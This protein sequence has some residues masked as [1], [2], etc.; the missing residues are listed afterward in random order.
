[1][2]MTLQQS[3]RPYGI[4]ASLGVQERSPSGAAGPGP[5]SWTSKSWSS[6]TRTRT[7]PRRSRSGCHPATQPKQPPPTSTLLHGTH[8]PFLTPALLHEPHS[9]FWTHLAKRPTPSATSTAATTSVTDLLWCGVEVLQAVVHDLE[10]LALRR[11]DPDHVFQHLPACP[12]PFRRPW[13]R[14]LG[15]K[16]GAL[17]SIPGSDSP[18]RPFL[19]RSVP[20]TLPET[21]LS[22]SRLSPVSCAGSTSEAARKTQTTPNRL[23]KTLTPRPE[24]P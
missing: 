16:N 15:S 18:L 8:S 10:P 12:T 13:S 11:V 1:M 23:S 17:A 22:L 9:S 6:P 3:R 14:G 21:C 19:P 20:P 7:H 2:S 24:N 5:P 4:L